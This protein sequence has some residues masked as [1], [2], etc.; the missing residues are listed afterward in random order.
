MLRCWK[1]NQWN[2]C[3][4]IQKLVCSHQKPCTHN[5]LRLQ[6]NKKYRNQYAYITPM[7]PWHTCN[8]RNNY[9]MLDISWACWYPMKTPPRLSKYRMQSAKNLRLRTYIYGWPKY[10][11]NKLDKIR[12]IQW[13]VDNL[14]KPVKYIEKM[15]ECLLNNAM[16]WCSLLIRLEP[17]YINQRNKFKQTTTLTQT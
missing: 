13:R 15:R 4:H 2:I 12:Y 8:Q 14:D 7:Q 16:N 6:K 9:F 1:R 11:T 17:K 10:F 3:Q 5:W